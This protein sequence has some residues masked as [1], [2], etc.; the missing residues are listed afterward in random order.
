MRSN[1]V[2]FTSPV[3]L[4][5]LALLLAIALVVYRAEIT[6]AH[7]VDGAAE[8]AVADPRDMQVE[9]DDLDDDDEDDPQMDD[10]DTEGSQ[11]YTVQPGDNLWNIAQK[12]GV[13]FG[14]LKAQKSNPS[15]IQPG[16]QITIVN[17]EPDD[18]PP[19]STGGTTDDNGGQDAGQT[20][21]FIVRP[22]DTLSQIAE[23]L[24]VSYESLAAQTDDPSSIYPGQVFTYVSENRIDTPPL[25]TDQDGT[26]SDGYYTPAPG[27]TDYDG[28]DSDGY[29]TPA[30][31]D[32]EFGFFTPPPP[33]DNDGYHT[34]P[35]L[36][37]GY[38]T[39]PPPTDNDGYDTP[40]DLEYG[41]D[42]FLTPASQTD[43]G[44]WS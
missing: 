43:F 38:P 39:P 28:T 17:E 42:G 29:D 3:L 14:T 33:T 36:E 10:D 41:Y 40:P 23:Y 1:L 11:T 27:P 37:Y 9:N 32:L 13:P 21:E 19:T 2:E 31:P 8:L 34:P 24:G 26:D 20:F 25:F 6:Y 16:D 22:G 12:L 5:L 44:E 30:L 18:T 15:L 35:D 4:H 7:G